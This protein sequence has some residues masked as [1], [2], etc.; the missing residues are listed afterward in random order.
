[1]IS[2]KIIEINFIF[3]KLSIYN[4]HLKNS[5]LKVFPCIVCITYLITEL[6]HIM[7]L[8]RALDIPNMFTF[9]PEKNYLLQ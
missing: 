4:Y 7:L 1:M 8:C 6:L 3:D 2:V 9:A 5:Q